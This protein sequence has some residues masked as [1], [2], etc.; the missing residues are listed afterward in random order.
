[1]KK[2]LKLLG[3]MLLTK[4]TGNEVFTILGSEQQEPPYEGKIVYKYEV[5]QFVAV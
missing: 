1:M 2:L 5:G 3:E 4:A